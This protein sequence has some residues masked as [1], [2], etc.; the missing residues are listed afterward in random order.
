MR[1]SAR[2]VEAMEN[3]FR[4]THRRDMTSEER[5]QFRLTPDDNMSC[6]GGGDESNGTA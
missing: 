3:V 1:R 4:W 5:V 6:S 2:T